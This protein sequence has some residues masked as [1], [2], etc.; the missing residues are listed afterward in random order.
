MTSYTQKVIISTYNDKKIAVEKMMDYQ[1]IAADYDGTLLPFGKKDVSV[2]TV[3]AILKSKEK[4]IKFVLSTGRP[5]KACKDFLG[6][7]NGN[8]DAKIIQN[9]AEI[10]VGNEK[11]FEAK[12]T[13]EVAD[14]VL[15]EGRKRKVTVVCWLNDSLYAEES[16]EKLNDYK[17]ISGVEPVVVD[18][19][20]KINCEIPT[21]Y[22]WYTNEF[23]APVYAKEMQSLLKKKA[24]VHTTRPPFVEF[25]SPLASKSIALKLV[26]EELGVPLKKTIAFGDGEN[27]IG[28][29]K[30][31]G[32]SVAMG[33]ACNKLKS[34]ASC[35][36]PSCDEDGFAKYVERILDN[37]HNF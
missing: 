28:L 37:E 30:C 21:K 13:K 20:S 3:S 22:L 18:D 2:A 33:N 17:K 25:V 8:A 7:I 6:A 1:L 10:Y 29:L 34:I 5:L 9:G 11:I 26:C 36:C 24:N 32:L 27:D 35:I 14:T 15:M 19:L 23:L 16:D 4:S 31:A 12:L